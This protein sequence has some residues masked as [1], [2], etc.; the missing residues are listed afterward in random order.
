M[1]NKGKNVLITGGAG[2]IG[3]ILV[4][5]MLK[6]GYEVTV[7]DS[8]IFNQTPLLDCCADL[9]FEFVQGDI[10]DLE[11]VNS[12]LPDFDIIIPLA[13]MVGAP[14]CR[15]NPSLTRLVNY[16]AHMNIVRNV[17][18]DQKIF[19]PTTNSGYGIG[20]KNAYCTEES[21]LRPISEYGRMKVEIE[22]AF[23]VKGNAVTFRLA[24]VFGMSP[25]MRMDLLVNDFVYRAVNDRSLVLFEENFRRNYIHVRDVA[26]AFLFGIENYEKM[27]GEPYNVGLSSANLTKRQL[28]E[29][30]KEYVPELYIHSAEIGEDPDKRDYIV[31]NDKIESLSWRPDHTLDDGIQELIKGYQIMRPNRFANV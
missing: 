29:K 16:D 18:K 23:L 20:E 26:K 27:K 1:K 6:E 22:K 10:C 4:P 19:F 3:S 13:A 9:N 5:N 12:L 30:I 24:T 11:L 2:Y 7:L 25:R 17:S 8:L 31:S 21:P 28:A 14:A 15:R